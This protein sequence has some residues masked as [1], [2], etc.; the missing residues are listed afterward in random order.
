MKI[1]KKLTQKTVPQNRNLQSNKNKGTKDCCLNSFQV[2]ISPIK[3]EFLTQI[4]DNLP[5][6]FAGV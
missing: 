4:L 5:T 6:G 2:M 3:I 1:L